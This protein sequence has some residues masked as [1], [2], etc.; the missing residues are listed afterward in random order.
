[1]LLPIFLDD[2]PRLHRV[3][4]SVN[5]VSNLQSMLFGA[6]MV[7]FL[8]VEPQSWARCGRGKDK[9]RLGRSRVDASIGRGLEDPRLAPEGR[10]R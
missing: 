1:V 7:F 10:R 3:R 4:G 2:A 9:L 5:L 8:I 6:L